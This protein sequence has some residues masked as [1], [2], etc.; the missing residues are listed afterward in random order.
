MNKSLMLSCLCKIVLSVI[1]I[2]LCFFRSKLFHVTNQGLHIVLSIVALAICLSSI[3]TIYRSL[4]EIIAT[5]DTDDHVVMDD[6]TR[7]D[8]GAF[9]SVAALTSLLEQ[10]DI[11]DITIY[12]HERLLHIG[13]SSEAFPGKSSFF[14]KQYYIGDAEIKFDVLNQQLKLLSNSDGQIAVVAIDDLHP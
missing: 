12:A 10:N 13:A 11:I 1:L 8:I 5:F 14:N 2:I 7:A 6:A 9:Y 4:F 3:L